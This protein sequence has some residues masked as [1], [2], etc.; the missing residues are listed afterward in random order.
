MKKYLLN[1]YSALLIFALVFTSCA[2]D[3]DPA[4]IN[5]NGLLEASLPNAIERSADNA[6]IYELDVPL[7]SALTKSGQLTYN[8]DGEM[9]TVQAPEGATSFKI[10]V[11]MSNDFIRTVTIED[12]IVLY[13]SAQGNSAVVSETNNVTKVV[14]GPNTV[15]FTFT[16]D[17]DS[18]LDCGTITRT[19]LAGVN[20]SQ[21]L[22][23]PE[24]CVLPGD[25]PNGAYEFAI[26]PWTVNNSEILCNVEVVNG[27]TVTN[28][29]AS[30]IDGIPAGFFGYNQ[31]EAFLELNK[32]TAG[33]EITQVLF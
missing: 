19:P 4:S 25:V 29:S 15:V 27:T 18:D 26:L 6:T 16:W 17:D 23:Q 32:T 8:V 24:V 13:S 33:V 20:L 3:D 21:L 14:K 9:G 31:I 2:L 5:T 28:Y 22:T 12:L 30:L 1:K 10:P 11:D 7:S